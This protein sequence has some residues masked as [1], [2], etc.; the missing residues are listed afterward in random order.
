MTLDAKPDEND[1]MPDSS[2][3][4]TPFQAQNPKAESGETAFPE[5]PPPQARSRR[6]RLFIL[7]GASVAV[8]AVAWLIYWFAIGQ[9]HITTDNAYVNADIADITPLVSGPV[10]QVNVVDT[11]AVKKG[12]TLVVIDDTDFRVALMAAQRPAGPGSAKG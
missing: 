4:P 2:E 9:N 7:V 10:V 11:Q 5:L 1:S 3:T 12:Q 6:Q 8:A